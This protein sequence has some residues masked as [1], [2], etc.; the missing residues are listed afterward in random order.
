M[1][2]EH[3]WYR[4]W[5]VYQAS[6]WKRRKKIWTWLEEARKSNTVWGN[7]TKAMLIDVNNTDELPDHSKV[8][9]YF[10][11]W[12][13]NEIESTTLGYE[14]TIN[15]LTVMVKSWWFL[16]TSSSRDIYKWKFLRTYRLL[17]HQNFDFVSFN[18][19]NSCE[20]F[21]AEIRLLS[22]NQ[23]N[24]TRFEI[25]QLEIKNLE[26][27]CSRFFQNFFYYVVS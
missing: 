7:F 9:N 6:D 24:F 15:W 27:T 21:T 12:R 26:K 16:S 19:L 5:T 11:H 25:A 22:I 1:Y 17:D 13:N 8:K 3:I 23:H 14:C 18:C 20:R 2:Q 4:W 10:R